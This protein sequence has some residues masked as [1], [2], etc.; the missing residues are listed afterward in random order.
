MVIKIFEDNQ[1]DSLAVGQIIKLKGLTNRKLWKHLFV[2]TKVLS[3]YKIEVS[4][5]TSLSNFPEERLSKYL[6]VKYIIRDWKESELN[7]ESLIS[8]DTRGILN[9]NK[10]YEILGSLTQYDLQNMLAI[11]NKLL[12]KDIHQKVEWLYNKY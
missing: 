6:N 5:I 8:L 1:I 3:K 2:V 9:T 4:P 12:K 7:H 10:V 11:R